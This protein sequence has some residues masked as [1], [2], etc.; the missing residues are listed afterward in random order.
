MKFL[1]TGG[2]V[3]AYLDDVK[4]ITNKFKGGR[5]ETLASE[6]GAAGHDVIYLTSKYIKPI[7]F[8]GKTILHDGFKDYSKKVLEYSS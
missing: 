2:P 1:V 3:H 4:I 8:S 6:L 5:M 7:G